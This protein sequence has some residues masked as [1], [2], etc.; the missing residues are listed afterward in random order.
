[1]MLL[2]P[3][4]RSRNFNNSKQGPQKKH[5]ETTVNN[6]PKND[7]EKNQNKKG[8]YIDYEEIE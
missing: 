4:F 2:F 3:V 7:Y 5:G 8:D 6:I 1:M